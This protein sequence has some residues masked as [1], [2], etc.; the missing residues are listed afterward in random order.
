MYIIKS[1]FFCYL[2]I[3]IYLFYLIF[4]IVPIVKSVVPEEEPAV[5]CYCPGSLI[6][7]AVSVGGV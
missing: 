2:E 6:G 3:Y 4:A 7:C 1:L 5:Y